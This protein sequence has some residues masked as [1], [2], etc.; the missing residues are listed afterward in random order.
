MFLGLGRAPGADRGGGFV[1]R[2]LFVA[3]EEQVRDGLPHLFLADVGIVHLT[4]VGGGRKDVGRNAE[5]ILSGVVFG[6]KAAL[7]E[8]DDAGTI[9]KDLASALFHD[10][11][12][13]VDPIPFSLDEDRH[14][15]LCGPTLP[16]RPLPSLFK[17]LGVGRE[18]VQHKPNESGEGALSRFVRAL[19]DVQFIAELD[20]AIVKQAEMFDVDFQYQ[21][22]L[23]SLPSNPDNPLTARSTADFCSSVS[24]S[25]AR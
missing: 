2:K 19:D 13:T 23:T 4:D 24:G 12:I 6:N 5:E 8:I 25:S 11:G 9:A 16:A 14:L 7:F 22:G 3:R 21:H 10:R 1:D 18:T 17:P 15:A 20:V